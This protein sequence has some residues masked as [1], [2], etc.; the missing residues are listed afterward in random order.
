M[1]S[2][3]RRLDAGYRRQE[4][5]MK[6]YVVFGS[7]CDLAVFRALLSPVRKYL[8]RPGGSAWSG[9]PTPDSRTSK[10]G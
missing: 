10:E 2:R 5:I 4:A 7:L 8:V 9:R 3:R 6:A 1:T